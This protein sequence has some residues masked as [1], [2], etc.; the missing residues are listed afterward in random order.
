MEESSLAKRPH[1]PLDQLTKGGLIVGNAETVQ[2]SLVNM[3]GLALERITRERSEV[4]PG[5]QLPERP[6]YLIDPATRRMIMVTNREHVPGPDYRRGLFAEIVELDEEGKPKFRLSTQHI[7]NPSDQYQP[8]AVGPNEYN[9]PP[10]YIEMLEEDEPGR[11][12][13]V[14]WNVYLGS[15]QS[16][17]NEITIDPN[18]D[19]DTF[20]QRFI[21]LTEGTKRKAEGKIAAAF[22]GGVQGFNEKV[23][24]LNLIISDEVNRDLYVN[25]SKAVGLFPLY[26][27]IQ[28][29]ILSEK[30]RAAAFREK[31]SAPDNLKYTLAHYLPA[32]KV[33]SRQYYPAL[34]TDDLT[35]VWRLE[36]PKLINS[37]M[38][39]TA[40]SNIMQYNPIFSYVQLAHPEGEGEVQK[41][42]NGQY[43]CPNNE[44]AYREFLYKTKADLLLT[45]FVRGGAPIIK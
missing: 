43:Y 38:S 32:D 45:M 9:M 24:P 15:L 28:D 25:A 37:G 42:A 6:V 34:I 30:Q 18:E 39:R 7:I 13:F 31:F 5:I 4:P 40:L 14:P 17:M 22:P 26:V 23:A 3:T 44:Q 8:V 11:P 41:K 20:M 1:I 10:S 16:W 36:D 29:F 19:F 2:G 12:K 33:Q 27:P 21:S 35:A